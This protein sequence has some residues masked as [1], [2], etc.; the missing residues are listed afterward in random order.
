[1]GYEENRDVEELDSWLE[2]SIRKMADE[3]KGRLEHIYDQ[4]G[5]ILDLNYDNLMDMVEKDSQE[6]LIENQ[7]RLLL[8]RYEV[9]GEF[10]VFEKWKELVYTNEHESSEQ[11]RL[12]T[13]SLIE[14][15]QHYHGK[16]SASSMKTLMEFHQTLFEVRR[17]LFDLDNIETESLLHHYASLLRVKEQS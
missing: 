1:M 14:M 9:T 7:Q 5:E 3:I 11:E 10:P 17:D 4:N 13:N 6:R 12:E 2:K 15:I 8:E 16:I